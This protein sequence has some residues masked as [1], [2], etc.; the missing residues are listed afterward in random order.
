MG[1]PILYTPARKPGTLMV[2]FTL[3]Q[4]NTMSNSSKPS[5]NENQP[6]QNHAEQVHE[7]KNQT[8]T[9]LNDVRNPK[10][11]QPHEPTAQHN[12]VIRQPR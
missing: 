1:K 2:H 11:Q 6:A 5:S 9:G 4:G 3:Q 10:T 7:R 8:P 12:R